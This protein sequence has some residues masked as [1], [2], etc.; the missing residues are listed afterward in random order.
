MILPL[1]EFEIRGR[2][3]IVL[4]WISRLR[5]DEIGVPAPVGGDDRQ[6]HQH[7]LMRDATPRFAAARRDDAIRRAIKLRHV[8]QR[9]FR[10]EQF[11]AGQFLRT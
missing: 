11:D 9:D 7:R 6:C 1:I 3:Q 2:D 4:E 8:G 10:G 5:A